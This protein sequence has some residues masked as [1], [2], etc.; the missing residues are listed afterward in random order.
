MVTT[1][2]TLAGGMPPRTSVSR[3][4]CGACGTG[5]RRRHESLGMSTVREAV[6]GRAKAP[7]SGVKGVCAFPWHV[8]GTVCPTPSGPPA[9]VLRA[10]PRGR[11]HAAPAGSCPLLGEAGPQPTASPLR[12][13]SALSPWA[14]APSDPHSPLPADREPP[15]LPRAGRAL[16]SI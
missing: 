10:H 8:R 14:C 3:G 11:G 7:D 15:G 6:G 12:G 16:G 9:P 1:E 5:A 13:Q 2:Q 4:V